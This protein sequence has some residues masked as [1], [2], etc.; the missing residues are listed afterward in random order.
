M[1]YLSTLVTCA[2]L[3]CLWV[4]PA[5]AAEERPHSVSVHAAARSPTLSQS[6]QRKGRQAQNSSGRHH[7]ES[8]ARIT[9]GRE[10]IDHSGRP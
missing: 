8:R 5:K 9:P 3:G 7:R 10:I 2:L 4:S 6:M 1:S